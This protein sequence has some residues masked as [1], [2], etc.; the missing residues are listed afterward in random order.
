MILYGTLS[1]GQEPAR[2]DGRSLVKVPGAATIAKNRLTLRTQGDQTGRDVG[3]GFG[4]KSS[5][6]SVTTIGGR[7]KSPSTPGW[8][9]NPKNGSRAPGKTFAPP[10]RALPVARD[11]QAAAKIGA[12]RARQLPAFL[13]FHV[14]APR[15]SV[16]GDA[17]RYASGVVQGGTAKSADR[18]AGQ[19]A[20]AGHDVVD[21]VIQITGQ[22][23]GTTTGSGK[24]ETVIP[25]KTGGAV[26]TWGFMTPLDI[27]AAPDPVVGPSSSDEPPPAVPDIPSQFWDDATADAKS[28]GLAAGKARPRAGGA[29]IVTVLGIGLIAYLVLR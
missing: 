4:I 27:P 15:E 3:S 9:V 29:T 7:A 5:D 6:G 25:P 26:K 21:D 22:Q 2:A 11:V 24:G 10:E 14:G 19:A 1:L 18:T 28:K 16:G 12:T 23:M 17:S 20:N 13:N 8:N